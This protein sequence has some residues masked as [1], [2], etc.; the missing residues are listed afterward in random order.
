MSFWLLIPSLLLIYLSGFIESG[1]AT[2]WTLEYG[3]FKILLDAGNSW[4]SN[5]AIIYNIFIILFQFIDTTIDLIIY[6]IIYNYRVVEENLLYAKINY[7]PRQS[8]WDTL[9]NNINYNI[10]QS[11]SHQRLNVRDKV[12]DTNK[13]NNWLVGFIDGDGTFN[14]YIDTKNNKIAFTFKLAQS[15]YN[16]RVLYYIKKKLNSGKIYIEK[17]KSGD[18]AYFLIRDRESIKNI[19]L[20][21]F[22]QIPLLTSKYYD[23]TIFKEALNIADNNFLSKIEKIQQIEKIKNN[24]ILDNYVSPGL[25]SIL[26]GLNKIDK[27]WLVGFT[28]AEG[29]FMINKNGDN[30][31]LEFGITQKKDSNLLLEIGK[32]FDFKGKMI[33]YN[34]IN[35]CYQL[36]SKNKNSMKLVIDYF[37]KTMKGMKALEYRIWSKAYYYTFLDKEKK[38][39]NLQH[40][41]NILTKLRNKEKNLNYC[42]IKFKTK[43]N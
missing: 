28:E 3:V 17:R 32:L 33:Y 34:K 11:M 15:I 27:S 37:R 12:I 10:N 31:N 29:S 41:K 43:I 19:I 21:I 1:V 30:F 23:Y 4:N 5:C 36:T 42:K 38:L 25:F 20:P 9:N 2:G 22:D 16:M 39:I 40:C 18:M 8:A 6:L 24:I 14:I 7:S 26:E 35:N 13:F